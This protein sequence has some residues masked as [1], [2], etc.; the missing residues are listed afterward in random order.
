M[1]KVKKKK[2]NYQNLKK[3]FVFYKKRLWI[4]S[5]IVVLSLAISGLKMLQI[6]FEGN[7]LGGFTT[8]DF[9]YIIKYSL[10]TLIVWFV[11]H[12][13][14]YCWSRLL[15]KLNHSVDF[16]LKSKL[17]EKLVSLKTKHFDTTNS[18][19]FISRVTHDTN[20]L[21]MFY[22]SVIDYFGEILSAILFLVYLASLNI[23]LALAVVVEIAIILVIE[24]FRIKCKFVN[25][26]NW[27]EA[28]DKAIGSYGETIRG[29]RDIKALNLKK[30][31]LSKVNSLQKDSIALSE[32]TEFTDNIFRRVRGCVNAIFVFLY[33]LLCIY[34]IKQGTLLPSAFF[35]VYLYSDRV[36]ILATYIANIKDAFQQG[37][38][39]AERV[40]D[41]LDGK[42]FT[43]EKFGT[44]ELSDVK[45]S[46]ELKN[47]EFSY[48]K[49]SE[50]FK[51]LNLMIEPNQAVAIVGKSGQGK[52]TI[53]NLIDRLY[54]I[55]S[56]EILI[57]DVNVKSLTENSLRDTVSIVMQTPY[58]FNTTIAE[59]LR[60]VNPDA[61][62]EEIVN[63]CKK[64]QIHDFINKL[65]HKYDSV[66]GENGIVLSGGQRQRLA[67]ARALLKNSK[68]ILFDESTS[69]LDNESQSKIKA[70]FDNLKADHTIVIV[71]HR[72]STIVDCDKIFVL[73]NNEIVS[74]GTHAELM[75][76]SKVYKELYLK[77][78]V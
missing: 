3:S 42:D 54:E 28:R 2:S 35:V 1:S 64:A 67:I 11:V 21:S 40:F 6:V 10:Y 36:R 16:D 5:L 8:L 32:K 29:V 65:P 41:I 76:N 68:I 27:K 75:K 13:L 24:Y 20:E 45:G 38:L 77:E 74:S 63:A 46:I 78:D 37:E 30:P 14:F 17:I 51:N 12:A 56:G 48:D 59:N 53:L 7:A 61:T 44:K 33:L 47:V 71:A 73:D 69:A 4:L 39:A 22:N 15:I 70:V 49:E 50:L 72:L 25:R 31:I 43:S 62:K 52:S 34:F 60:F 58:I 66:I 23:F 55:N 19:A 18:G 9:N 26:K 57:D